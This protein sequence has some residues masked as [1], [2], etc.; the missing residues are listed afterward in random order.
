MALNNLGLGFV[1]TAKDM[2]SGAVRGIRNNIEGLG[3]SSEQAQT[4]IDSAS[5]SM[6]RG[7][8]MMG[9]GAA[10]LG[11]VAAP[12]MVSASWESGMSEV[13]T[14]ADITKE[15]LTT[16]GD[17]ALGVMAKY[18]GELGNTTKALY[19]TLSA[20]I[21]VEVSIAFL[22]TAMMAATAGV[23]DA[24]TAVDGLTNV[25]NAYTN[26]SYTATQASDMMF[27]AIK[28]GKTTFGEMSH[29]IGEVN[30]LAN[31]L[32][33]GFDQIAAGFATMTKGGNNTAK[34]ATMLTAALMGV[35]QQQKI[36]KKMGP[37]VEAAFSLENLKGKGLQQWMVEVTESVD[38]SKLKLKELIGSGE[39]LNAILAMTGKNAETA[40]AD[41]W[42]VK[43]STGAT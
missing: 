12:M 29:S 43:H 28:G 15:K 32:G 33:L 3:S 5:A 40:A 7:L 14:V 17:E 25:L 20:S 8:K 34:S 41:L 10:I 19:N 2:A 38:D 16:M 27:A 42:P 9:G 11:A 30:G 39:A 4:K 1:F 18:G 37:E 35:L 21:P 26:Q 13:W 22:N 6:G 36:A 24:N 23:S 31:S